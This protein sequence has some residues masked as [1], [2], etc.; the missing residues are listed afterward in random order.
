MKQIILITSAFLMN[1]TMALSQQTAIYGSI[2]NLQDR[3]RAIECIPA[4]LSYDGKPMITINNYNN[5]IEVYDGDFQLVTT[6]KEQEVE[7]DRYLQSVKYERELLGVTLKKD[8]IVRVLTGYASLDDFMNRQNELTYYKEG[9]LFK[10]TINEQECLSYYTNP[11][12]WES[13][14]YARDYYGETYPFYYFCFDEV[15]GEPCIV[16]HIRVYEPQYGEWQKTEDVYATDPVKTMRIYYHNLD[17]NDSG[18]ELLA[19]QTLFNTDAS[20][21]YVMPILVH[22][23]GISISNVP[24]SG[25]VDSMYPSN[26]NSLYSVPISTVTYETLQTYLAGF[27]IRNETGEEI[28]RLMFEDG[29][30]GTKESSYCSAITLGGNSYMVFRGYIPVEEDKYNEV[31]VFYRIDKE[32]NSIKQ[33]R[34]AVNYGVTIAELEITVD[35]VPAGEMVSARKADGQLVDSRVSDGGPVSLKTR[36]GNIILSVGQDSQKLRLSNPK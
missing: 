31:T 20:F 10:T 33:V 34:S 21:E 25:I 28:S 18:V 4:E 23:P 7:G 19:T 1:A 13:N 36:G 17:R 32:S 2:Q 35:N 5:G 27:S 9:L 22:R 6:I 12:N 26:N 8:T 29:C 11:M 3:S 24:S 30:L 15:E 14:Y 16:Q